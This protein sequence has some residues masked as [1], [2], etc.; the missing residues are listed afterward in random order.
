MS[1]DIAD[2][3]LAALFD[4]NKIPRAVFW[5][6]RGA[7]LDGAFDVRALL[8]ALARCLRQ[9]HPQSPNNAINL[10]DARALVAAILAPGPS[11]PPDKI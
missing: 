10:H 6:V 2:P 9:P 1:T 3:E 4:R 5:G 7:M 11:D 8:E